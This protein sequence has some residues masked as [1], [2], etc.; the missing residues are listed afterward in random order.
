VAAGIREVMLAAAIAAAALLFGNGARAQNY[1]WC[2]NFADGAGTN[3]GFSTREECLLTISG[4][5]GYCDQNT[6][7][8]AA[9]AAPTQRQTPKRRPHK[10]SS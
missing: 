10:G 8:Q 7:Y 6:Q 1:P 4:S 3:C 5:G 9:A 2:S